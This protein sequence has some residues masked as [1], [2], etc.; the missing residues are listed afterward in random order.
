MARQNSQGDTVKAV[1]P[2]SSDGEQIVKL[3][4]GMDLTC[5]LFSNEWMCGNFTESLRIA[6]PMQ[7]TAISGGGSDRRARAESRALAEWLDK[8][9]VV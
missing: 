9:L 4:L 7:T 6:N 5:P 2:F 3:K 8:Y 1:A